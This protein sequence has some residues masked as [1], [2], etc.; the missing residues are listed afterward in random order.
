[1]QGLNRFVE[2]DYT[3]KLLIAA[4]YNLNPRATSVDRRGSSQ[5]TT[6]LLPSRPPQPR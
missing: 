3:H 2:K 6:I 1:M 5:T 4:A